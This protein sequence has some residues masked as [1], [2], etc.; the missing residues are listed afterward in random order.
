M[1][2]H[3]KLLFLSVFLIVATAVAVVVYQR[4]AR[5]A[6]AVLLLPEGNFLLYVNFSPVH[7]IDLGQLPAQSDPQYQDF[8][9]HTGFHFEH[10]LDG[11]AV[12]QHN[13]GDFNSESS[14]VFTGNFDQERLNSYMQ[15]L[16]GASETYAGKTIFSIRQ[17]G[18]V[19]RACIVDSKTVAVTNM[20]SAE[21]MH[22][23]I[24][25]ARGAYLVS[26]GPSLVRDYYS[27]VPF[28]SLA[29]AMFRMPTQSG[30]SQLPGGV[31]LNFLQN[32]TSV[33]SVRYTGSIRFRA[34]VISANEADAA[35]V[36][37][38]AN[39]LLLLG[40]GA[41]E[42]LSPGGPDKDVKAVVDSIQVQQNGNQTVLSVTIPQ[43]FVKKMAAS[44]NH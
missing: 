5:P 15:K 29:W 34:A 41:T 44:M 18:H 1:R 42:S 7:Y 14:A 8:L 16:S 11:I 40:K 13:P 35:R 17:E 27:Y 36:L 26:Q 39:T 32:T 30:A 3:R 38:A 25:K 22:G 28:A 24:D 12:S 10:D 19:V 6:R 33:F 9:Q 31:D 23:I 20:E 4:V 2:N 43:A 37:Q 21:P